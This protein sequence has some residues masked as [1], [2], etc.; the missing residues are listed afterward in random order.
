MKRIIDL[1]VITIAF[2]LPWGNFLLSEMMIFLILTLTAVQGLNVDRN[3]GLVLQGLERDVLEEASSKVLE[4]LIDLYQDKL[5]KDLAGPL[6]TNLSKKFT[7][8][9]NRKHI[10]E[11]LNKTKKGIIGKANKI[12]KQLMAI[13]RQRL[14][15]LDA[16]IDEEM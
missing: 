5:S 16:T 13:K 1:N 10:T 11:N 15:L 2:Y 14:D 12:S 3:L 8:L 6:V 7:E 4:V 9:A